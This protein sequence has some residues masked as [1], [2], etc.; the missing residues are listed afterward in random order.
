M[1][2]DSPKIER[3]K[4]RRA[5]CGI[6]GTTVDV[7][8]LRQAATIVG[9]GGDLEAVLV[10]PEPNVVGQADAALLR[11]AAEDALARA[12]AAR[13]REDAL[14]RARSASRDL[15]VEATAHVVIATDDWLGLAG[16]IDGHDLL[17]VGAHSHSRAEGILLGSVAT[18][19]LHLAEVPVLIARPTETPFPQRIAL[20]TDGSAD[21]RQAA[22]LTAEVAAAHDARVTLLT[23]GVTLDREHRHAL[24]EESA[25]LFQAVGVEPTL[26]E[27]DGQPGTAIV[28]AAA[29]MDAALVVVGS[30]GKKGLRA[31]GS[32]SEHVAHHAHC[33]VLVARHPR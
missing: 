2:N 26:E 27:L 23:V 18:R 29:V 3:R 22:A 19:A 6:D 12:S 8:V 25:D 15:G 30:G 24:A 14:A 4:L 33:S 28:E 21:S 11:G 10:A 5:L 16:A 1:T 32:V 7:E 31:I 20:A 17:V 13:H 9:A